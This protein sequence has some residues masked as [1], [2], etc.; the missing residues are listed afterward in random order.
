MGGLQKSFSDFS[1]SARKSSYFYFIIGSITLVLGLAF[2]SINNIFGT[3]FAPITP[4]ISWGIILLLSACVIRIVRMDI[5]YRKQW[6]EH[7]IEN[8][9]LRI[10]PQGVIMYIPKDEGGQN[11]KNDKSN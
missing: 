4:Y 2:N 6:I 8:T 5:Y 3:R 1:E 10:T 7:A 11:A 9:D